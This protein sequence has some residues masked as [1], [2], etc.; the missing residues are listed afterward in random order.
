[1]LIH[2]LHVQC[3]PDTVVDAGAELYLWEVPVVPEL[4]PMQQA[5][6]ACQGFLQMGWRA[7]PV[8]L[9]PA[10]VVPRACLDEPILTP[11]HVRLACTAPCRLRGM[12]LCIKMLLML[13]CMSS[14]VWGI[15]V[16]TVQTQAQAEIGLRSKSPGSDIGH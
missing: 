7:C 13:V 14:L 5:P 2:S 12:H 3:W 1:V 8:D 6:L 10:H 16:E 11:K 15:E 4:L 9:A